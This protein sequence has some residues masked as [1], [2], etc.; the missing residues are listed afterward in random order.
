MKVIMLDMDGV[1]NSHVE[2]LGCYRLLKRRMK[3]DT[4]NYLHM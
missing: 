2:Y 4:K 3:N 1:V